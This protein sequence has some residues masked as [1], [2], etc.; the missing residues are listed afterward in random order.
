MTRYSILCVVC[1]GWLGCGPEAPTKRAPSRDGGLTQVQLD[2]GQAYDQR[3]ATTGP[4]SDQEVEQL[5]GSA[6]DQGRADRSGGD[7]A[8]AVRDTVESREDEAADAAPE[9][10]L[11]TQADGAGAADG[12][13]RSIDAPVACPPKAATGI[14]CAKPAG[15]TCTIDTRQCVCRMDMKWSCAPAPKG[16]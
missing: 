15:F 6:A 4:D 1:L 13:A 8:V 16:L 2:S 3:A 14:A 7:T 9:I 12:S 5:D 11:G 10:D